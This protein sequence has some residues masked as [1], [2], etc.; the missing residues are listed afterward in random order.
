MINIDNWSNT[1]VPGLWIFKVGPLAP[2]ENVT[3]PDTGV[4]QSLFCFRT[5]Y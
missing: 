4:S 3:P 2:L 1:N 5:D